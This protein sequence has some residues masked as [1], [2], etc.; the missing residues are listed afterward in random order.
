MAVVLP[1]DLLTVRLS[2]ISE[3]HYDEYLPGKLPGN[4]A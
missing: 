1:Q 3:L 2:M 4:L